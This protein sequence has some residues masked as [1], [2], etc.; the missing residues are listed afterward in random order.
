MNLPSSVD[1]SNTCDSR[2]PTMPLDYPDRNLINQD[3]FSD[4]ERWHH[5][6]AG[7]LE[8]IE[9]GGMRMGCLGSRQGGPGCMAF[10]RSDLP[11]G[12]A[13]TYDLVV[14][15]HGGLIINYLALRGVNG[16]DVI[17]DRDRLR[18]RT[19]VMKNYYA[20]KWGLQSYHVSFSRFD[21]EGHHTATSNWRRN[22]GCILAG[23]GTDLVRE[24]GRRYTIRV[25]K[26]FGSLQ[27]YVDGAFAH[28]IIDRSEGRHPIPDWGK[29]GFRL[30]GSNVSADVFNFRVHRIDPHPAPRLN[31]EDE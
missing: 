17:S 25:T 11:D 26:D 31:L 20:A 22:P 18:P 13:V 24:I 7:Q 5:E 27:L 9:G 8:T 4:L 29:F 15:S 19:G 1:R 21:D 14:N 23:H 10:F 28:G 30:I 3:S 16:E 6:G 2:L 12:I